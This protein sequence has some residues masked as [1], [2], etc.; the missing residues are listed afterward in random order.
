MSKSIGRNSS[1][2]HLAVD[3]Y[4]NPIEIMIP[5]GTTHGVKISPELVTKLDLEEVEVLCADKGY[6]SELL[7]EKIRTTNTKANI[8]RKSNT[9][10]N[11]DHMDWDL[12]KI[13][14]LVENTFA[15]L[16][17]F[18][19]IAILYDKLKCNYEK[20]RCFSL[21]IHLVA[22]MKFQQTLIKTEIFGPI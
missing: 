8:P 1:R 17:H 18:R 6:D 12:Y 5:K 10:S 13:R 14:H 22:F 4:G 7:L 2:I 15:R 19:G 9:Q 21:Y 16:K 3:S 20:C 11:N